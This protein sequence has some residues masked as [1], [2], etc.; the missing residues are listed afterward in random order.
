MPSELVNRFAV[1]WFCISLRHECSFLTVRN[2][3]EALI[4]FTSVSYSL[5]GNVTH[6]HHPKYSVKLALKCSL[7]CAQHGQVV[8]KKYFGMHQSYSPWQAYFCRDK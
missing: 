8:P 4:C 5:S 7:Q 1:N 3:V 6:V 2:Q